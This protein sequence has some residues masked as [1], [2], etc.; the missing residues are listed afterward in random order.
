MKIKF[1]TNIAFDNKKVRPRDIRNIMMS[2]VSAINKETADKIGN[3]DK[4]KHSQSLFVYPKPRSRSFELIS[5]ADDVNALAEVEAVLIG[6]SLSLGGTDVVVSKC[7]WS[8]EGYAKT[9]KELIIYKTRTPIVISSNSIEHKIVHARSKN[10]NLDEYIQQ[11]ILDLIKIQNK[12]FFGKETEMDDF[13]IKILDS[14]KVTVSADS[15]NG[16]YSQAVFASFVS[17]YTLPRFVGYL[18]GLGYGELLDTT[19]KR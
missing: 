5:Y 13:A 15:T 8:D 6:K 10:G 1:F 9:E 11:K 3:K 17:S 16:K 12:E 7:E 18:S 14:N 2:A 19:K 4:D